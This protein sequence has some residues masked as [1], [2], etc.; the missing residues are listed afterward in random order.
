MKAMSV[1][2][3]GEAVIVPGPLPLHP[4][5][6]RPLSLMAVLSQPVA[7]IVV[8]GGRL[9]PISVGIVLVG[10]GWVRG[11][12]PTVRQPPIRIAASSRTLDGTALDILVYAATAWGSDP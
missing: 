12:T 1:S 11:V 9:L 5:E 4:G 3:I 7:V 8:H 10:V 2:A 6:P